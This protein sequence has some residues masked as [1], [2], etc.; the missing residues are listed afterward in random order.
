MRPRYLAAA[1][2][3]ITATVIAILE[4]HSLSQ[5]YDAAHMLERLPLQGS[6]KIWVDFDQLRASGLLDLLAGSPAAED[7]DYRSFTQQIGFDYRT[8][9]NG[10]AAVYRQGNVYLAAHGKFDFQKLNAYAQTQQGHCEDSVCS[11]PASQTGRWVSFYPLASEAL[12]FASSTEPEGV[13]LIAPNARTPS[14]D[15]QAPVWI[16][17]PGTTFSGLSHLPSGTQ[18]FL[19]PLADT[20]ESSFSVGPT[21]DR[22]ALQ[23]QLDASCPSPQVASQLAERLTSVTDILRKML[24]RDHLT[25]SSSDLTSLL[26]S[27]KFEA[28]DLHATGTWPLDRKLLENL[29]SGKSP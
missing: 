27:G 24:Q 26:S 15:P 25:P 6:V 23:I 4:W 8:N 13:R 18:A 22:K 14:L 11:V 19:S 29:A 1:L 9:L 21:A 7:P 12:A 17:A 2:A 3:F 20:V 28:H 10:V 16:S 5:R